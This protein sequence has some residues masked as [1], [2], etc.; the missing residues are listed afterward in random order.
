MYL[1]C[2]AVLRS[3][4]EMFR[5]DYANYH[6]GGHITPAHLLSLG[7]FAMGLILLFKRRRQP[8]VAAWRR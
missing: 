7:I 5:D 8:V 4:V 6:F 2:Y 3:F 1:I